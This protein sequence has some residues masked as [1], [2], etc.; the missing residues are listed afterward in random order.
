MITLF[1]IPKPFEGH[2]AIIQKNA[3]KSWTLL[4]PQCEIILFGNDSGVD[5]IA[6]EFNVLH[7]PEIKRNEYGTPLL[8]DVFYKADKIAK[9]NVLCYV[10]ADIILMQ[11]FI[12]A[13]T[14]VNKKVRNF[15]LVGERW[16]IEINDGLSFDENWDAHLKNHT[17]KEG[18][19]F[20][21]YGIDYFVFSRH[22]WC[23][24]P[25]FA[26][27]RTCWDNWLLFNAESRN[28]KVIDGSQA[29]MAIHQNHNYAHVVDGDGY[30]GIESQHNRILTGDSRKLFSLDQAN[31]FLDDDLGIH[32]KWIN[33]FKMPFIILFIKI[34]DFKIKLCPKKIF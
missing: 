25:P 10:N 6:R 29:I 13:V 12:E 8:N 15:L 1:T 21:R 19:L 11:D 22:L 31:Y 2:N 27:G 4:H 33:I 16:N 17:L 7:I 23:D 3:I 26:I 14:S 9:N 24:I 28:K 30:K 18:E 32:R 5:E 34:I 20:S